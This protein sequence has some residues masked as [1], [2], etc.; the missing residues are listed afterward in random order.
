[1]QVPHRTVKTLAGRAVYL[2]AP[3]LAVQYLRLP[4][5]TVMEQSISLDNIVGFLVTTPLFDG[6][7]AA[8]RA[9]VV[10][11]LEVTRLREG[12]KVFQEGD[13]GDAWYVISEGAVRVLKTLDAGQREIARLTRGE[14]FGEMAMLDRS[15]RSA[16]VEAS[17]DVTL[18]RFRR[19]RFEELLDQGSLGAFKLVLAMARVLSQRQRE[20]TRQFAELT[21]RKVDREPAR[22]S[23]HMYMVSE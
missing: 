23:V 16:T 10:R 4:R 17:T 21:E 15:A 5:A 13:P 8:E 12:E 2:A 18:F 6:L 7:D 11:I 19:A 22:A 20:L 9:D 3:G 14:C 1:M